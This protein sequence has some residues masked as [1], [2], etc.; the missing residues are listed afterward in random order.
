M[1]LRVVFNVQS[2][3]IMTSDN[4]SKVFAME[5]FSHKTI[6]PEC[7]TKIIYTITE[8]NWFYTTSSIRRVGSVQSDNVFLLVHLRR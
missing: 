7:C 1:V 5:P 2:H 6:V 4:L 3:Y 8:M